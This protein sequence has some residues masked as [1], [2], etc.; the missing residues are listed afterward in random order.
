[1]VTEQL[2]RLEREYRTS[3]KTQSFMV[4]DCVDDSAFLLNGYI[5]IH[6]R[7]LTKELKHSLSRWK[8]TE[9]E[10]LILLCFLGN[11]SDV[12]LLTGYKSLKNP[13]KS[14][15]IALDNVLL[16]APSYACSDYL[17]RHCRF[18]DK[19][20]MKVGDVFT[21]PYYLNTSINKWNQDCHQYYITI[22]QGVTK[23]KSLYLIRDKTGE[24]QVTFMRDSVFKVTNIT[25]N[26][27][28]KIF[29][30]QEI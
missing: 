7:D 25:S 21:L 17:Y 18:R 23:A 10:M 9:F 5:A 2:L 6:S 8:L 13:I 3:H 14:M 16:K 12:F 30:L 20:D 24:R 27:K 28:Y 11:L 22:K 1:M 15:C 4:E 29:Y 26:G 19:T